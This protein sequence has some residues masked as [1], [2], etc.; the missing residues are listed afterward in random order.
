MNCLGRASMLTTRWLLSIV[1]ALHVDA[2]HALTARVR[3]RQP[4][5]YGSLVCSGE[6][7]ASRY[8][9]YPVKIPTVGNRMQ[10]FIHILL[11]VSPA[12]HISSSRYVNLESVSAH[13][14]NGPH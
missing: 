11:L 12:S 7:P 3:Q 4:M 10:L 9:S 14:S 13:K 1:D 8:L 5:Y 6:T 2:C